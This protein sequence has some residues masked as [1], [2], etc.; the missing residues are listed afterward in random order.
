VDVCSGTLVVLLGTGLDDAAACFAACSVASCDA[1]PSVD[2]LPPS[3]LAV[4]LLR[5]WALGDAALLACTRG[6]EFV[7]EGLTDGLT[8]A[9]L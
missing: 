3:L 9:V 1:E 8:A 2:P 4:A 5:G 7:A 6:A